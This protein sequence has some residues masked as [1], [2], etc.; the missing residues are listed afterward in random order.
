[1]KQSFCFRD[2]VLHLAEVIHS[3]SVFF[4]IDRSITTAF[5]RP[6]SLEAESAFQSAEKP[7]VIVVQ[8]L[9]KTMISETRGNTS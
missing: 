6:I 9:V 8:Q 2:P 1:L 7:V 4:T 5:Q 3:H